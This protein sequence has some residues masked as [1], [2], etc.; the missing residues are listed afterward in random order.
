MRKWL[1]WRIIAR[2]WLI[3]SGRNCTTSANDT[4][5]AELSDED[6]QSTS[7]KFPFFFVHRS[8]AVA[9]VSIQGCFRTDMLL[10]RK[11]FSSSPITII[12]CDV[13]Y[14]SCILRSYIVFR[15]IHR[16]IHSVPS[17]YSCE[18]SNLTRNRHVP[19]FI[20]ARRGRFPMNPVVTD[21]RLERRSVLFVN[22]SYN[23][24]RHRLRPTEKKFE[25]ETYDSLCLV[26]WYD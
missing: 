23:Q 12:R 19:R 26:R 11:K 20:N 24:H 2:K 14:P 5:N 3:L 8:N 13:L 9:L 18:K 16:L 25:I 4:L 22:D 17:W 7:R 1:K 15:A 10:A 21:I 6:S